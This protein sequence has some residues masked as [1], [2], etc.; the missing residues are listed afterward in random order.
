MTTK[1]RRGGRPQYRV[2]Q[3]G[4]LVIAECE[5]CGRGFLSIGTRSDG[6]DPYQP[7]GT[8]QTWPSKR[9]GGEIV[10]LSLPAAPQEGE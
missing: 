10:L 1:M 9:C 6:L 3:H 7:Q 5:K 8:R 4:A 2:G